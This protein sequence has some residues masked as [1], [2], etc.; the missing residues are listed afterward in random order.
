MKINNRRQTAIAMYGLF[1]IIVLDILFLIFAQ[2][3]FKISKTVI[4]TTFLVIF[5]FS[6]WKIVNLKSISLEVTEHI[7][8]V[9]YN[10]PL[11]TVR[12]PVLE[13]PLYKIIS[14]KTERELINYIL[15]ISIRTK[16]GIRNF[17]YGVG[18]IPKDQQS[19]F[20]TISDFVQT[21]YD[22]SN[23]LQHIV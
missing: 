23:E 5:I 2:H 15:I 6:V 21:S 12:H 18:Q 19:K 10:H 4:Y 8:S 7:F 16:K 11:F 3:F 17:H 20:Q 14:V 9:K 22:S 13:V 1:L